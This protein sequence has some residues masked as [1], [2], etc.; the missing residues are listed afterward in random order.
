MHYLH[1]NSLFLNV[2]L[3]ALLKVVPR[4]YNP[5]IPRIFS[6]PG[7]AHELDNINDTKHSPRDP[8]MKPSMRAFSG[9]VTLLEVLNISCASSI[10]SFVK[11]RPFFASA[12]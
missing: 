5:Y 1:F 3:K 9:L 8:A 2:G 4:T 7:S 6:H 11:D 12:A 10:C